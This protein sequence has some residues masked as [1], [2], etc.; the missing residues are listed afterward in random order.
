I[1]F[2]VNC[3]VASAWLTPLPRMSSQTRPAFC[4]EVRMPRAVAIASTMA[5]PLRCRAAARARARG[6]S[7]WRCG[8]R[9]L[10]R[11]RG[12]PLERARRREL[13]ELVTHHVLGD[14]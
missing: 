8:R 5:L 13:A 2:R 6:R 11:L 10:F 9:G 3:S 12:V 1:V 7:G 4:A 14:V